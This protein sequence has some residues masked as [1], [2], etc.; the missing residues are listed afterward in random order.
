MLKIREMAAEDIPGL[1]D[2]APPDWNVDLS[3]IFGLHFGQPYFHPI[4]AELDGRVVGCANGLVQG[5]TGWLGNIIVLPECR[6]R[7]I[8]RALTEELVSLFR[9]KRLEH[10]IL[11]ATAMGEPVY[12]RLGF[13]VSTQYSFWARQ[14]VVA[15]PGEVAGIRALK[16]EDEPALFA[17]DAAVT[18]ESREP[19]LRRYLTA[20]RVHV[21]GN[22]KQDG[23]YLPGLGAGLIIAAGDEAGLA[24]LSY[25]LGQPGQLCVVPERNTVA[26]EFLRA[27]GFVQTSQ[28]PRMS[29]GPDVDWQPEHV[30]CRGSGF[31]G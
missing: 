11:I 24:L 18:G 20:A 31:C 3:R 28:A 1:R 6:M 2:F 23:Y 5:Q 4:A 29:L 7:G 13:Q 15:S 10:Q 16:P 9:A 26:A 17:L 12:R 25:K 14:A 19:F 21:D 22:D 30:Y 8:G 27:N